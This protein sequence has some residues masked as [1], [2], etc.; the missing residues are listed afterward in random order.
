[1]FFVRIFF[2]NSS[3]SK[4]I[5]TSDKESD[6]D[7]TIASF[8]KNNIKLYKQIQ[9]FYSYGFSAS[10][11]IFDEKKHDFQKNYT[12]YLPKRYSLNR[13]PTEMVLIV[14]MLFKKSM[15]NLMLR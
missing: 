9:E 13:N 12:K 14:I 11:I 1:M 7:E 5:N 4:R 10:E 6:I 3:N 15:E 8:W 2:L